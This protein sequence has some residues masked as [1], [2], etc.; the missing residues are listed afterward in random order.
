MTSM[1]F[2]P[3]EPHCIPE[4][5]LLVAASRVFHTC[6]PNHQSLASTILGLVSIGSWLFAQVPQIIKNTQR[7][8]VDGLSWGFLMLWLLG[9]ICNLTGAVM[10]DQMWFQQIIAA[11]YVF[12]DTVLVTQFLW[13]GVV[14]RVKELEKRLEGVTI[15]GNS[16]SDDEGDSIA[17]DSNADLKQKRADEGAAVA[18]SKMP[19]VAHTTFVTVSL[20]GTLAG[21]LPVNGGV[22]AMPTLGDVSGGWLSDELIEA[23]GMT[24]GW[25]STLLYLCSRLPQLILNAK[26]K[27][28]EGLSIALFM[29]AFSG[30]LFYS[31]SLLLNPLGWR[32]YEPY[33]GGGVA[34]PEGSNAM[35][36]WSRTLPF[37]FGAFGV[38]TMDAAV[39]LQFRLW[40]PG[41]EKAQIEEEERE[42][43]L[44]AR[45]AGYGSLESS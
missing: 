10:L 1:L 43:L 16:N 6:I 39:G 2:P 15:G 13:Y 14:Y 12:V 35:E 26:R 7:Q 28:T 20:L 24:V 22:P 44:T 37:F 17:S 36:W 4:S 5:D 38:L 45:E 31:G 18:R 30:N 41:S 9:D 11:Y 32:D 34:G 29:A 23:I 19:S 25:I 40:G 27:S 33:G 42:G 8:S 21:A 3:L